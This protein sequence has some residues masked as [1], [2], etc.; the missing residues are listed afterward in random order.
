M[1]RMLQVDLQDRTREYQQRLVKLDTPL[2][3]NMR[4]E[5]EQEAQELAAEQGRLAELVENML[6]RDNK[7]DESVMQTP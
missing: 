7:Q 6:T 5:L 1:L 3:Q 2:D 4:A